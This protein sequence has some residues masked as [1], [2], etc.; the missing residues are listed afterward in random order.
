MPV[1]SGTHKR[2]G[3]KSLSHPSSRCRPS[4]CGTHGIRPVRRPYAAQ[5]NAVANAGSAS[6]D[7][8]SP[9]AETTRSRP[10]RFARYSRSSARRVQLARSSDGAELEADSSSWGRPVVRVGEVGRVVLHVTDRADRPSL[11]QLLLPVDELLAEVGELVG[12]HV[13]AR[14]VALVGDDRGLRLGN[15]DQC[16]VDVLRETSAERGIDVTG[17]FAYF[18]R[19]PPSSPPVRPPSWRPVRSPRSSSSR[20]PRSSSRSPPSRSSPCS[21]GEER[22][23][24]PARSS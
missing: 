18:S 10:S 9:S 15:L 3:R 23:S 1:A 8:P 4:P 7:T 14:A 22:T 6:P 16:V 17:F 2:L 19:R 12:V 21:F 24:S 5:S 13:V 11:H 20:R